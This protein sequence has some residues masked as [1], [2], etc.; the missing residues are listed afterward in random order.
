MVTF[1]VLSALERCRRRRHRRRR[2]AEG[3][4][5]G[6]TWFARTDRRSGGA[7]GRRAAAPVVEIVES[8]SPSPS[9]KPPRRW[10]RPSSQ[11]PQFVQQ[12]PQS[13]SRPV[14]AAAAP[15]RRARRRAVAPVA[16]AAAPVGRRGGTRCGAS[17][18]D[19]CPVVEVATPVVE[20]VAPVA[21]VAEDCRHRRR[22][23]R[24]NRRT[25][26]RGRSRRTRR[27][28]RS[29]CR[30][31]RSA[32][33][34][35]RRRSGRH[36]CSQRLHRSSKRSR[37]SAARVV[38]VLDPVAQAVGRPGRRDRRTGGRSARV[39]DGP[40]RRRLIGSV[41]TIVDDVISPVAPIIDDVITPIPPI[42]DDV[43]SPIPP[44]IEDSID[45]VE[46]VAPRPVAEPVHEPPAVPGI[47]GTPHRAQYPPNPTAASPRTA[48]S[49]VRPRRSSP[50]RRLDNSVDPS[51][52]A[53]RC[54]SRS[55]TCG[56]AAVSSADTSPSISAGCHGPGHDTFLRGH[57]LP[58][59]PQRQ[60]HR[61]IGSRT[62][63]NNVHR[64]RGSNHAP[65]P[66]SCPDGRSPGLDSQ[67][68]TT[69]CR[70]ALAVLLPIECPG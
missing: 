63:G 52:P 43:I 33:R 30:R 23:T 55:D 46:P 19:R 66:R 70:G 13:S 49:T 10:S 11:S 69:A 8:Q 28:S 18:R 62:T 54:R 16:E 39:N 2:P 36:P 50:P 61:S 35:A 27:R 9:P 47:T 67:R 37:W 15:C 21:P 40:G 32:S 6:L 48:G 51:W 56:R 14:A 44:I 34:R 7:G 5:A 41:T 53:C 45:D 24:R 4:A 59:V 17:R 3:E 68:T 65:R 38:D 20:A 31:G 57:L 42:V 60:R 29:T 12:S 58:G 25:R 26:G 22:A 1:V 64:R